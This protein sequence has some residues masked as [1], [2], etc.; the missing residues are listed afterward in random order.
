MY[1]RDKK[2]CLGTLS[3]VSVTELLVLTITSHIERQVQYR[4]KTH[5]LPEIQAVHYYVAKS[6]TT[7]TVT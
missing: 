1:T 6:Q 5:F 4:H 7:F 2:Y 3:V